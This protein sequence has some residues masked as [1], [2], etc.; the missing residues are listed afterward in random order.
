MPAPGPPPLGRGVVVA[1]RDPAPAPWS[2]V[3]EVVVDE[4]A[5]AAPGPV[6]GALHAAWAARRPVVVRLLVEPSAFRRPERVEV[7]PWRLPADLELWADRLH[8]LVWANT[9]D[10][11]HGE[12]VWW[13]GRKAA[14]LGAEDGGPA[15]VALPD[16]RPA[17]VDGGPRQPLAVDDV[18]VHRE[19]VELGR[20]TPVRGAAPA[21]ELAPDQLAAVTSASGAARIVAPAGSGKTRVLAERLRHLVHDRGIEPELITA[22]AYNRRAADELAGRTSDVGVRVRTIHSLGLSILQRA[23]RRTVLGERDVRQILDGMVRLQHRPNTDPMAPYLEALGE[24]RLG[25]RDPAVVE[26]ERDDVAGLAELVPRYRARL[27]ELGAVDFDEQVHGALEL[28]LTDPEARE[29]ARR[30]CRHLLVDEFQDL[31]PA[32]VLLV[33]LLAAPGYQLFGV[34]DDDQVIYGY[35]G[36]D[37]GFL[38][39]FAR[40]VPAAETHALEVNYR[41]PP[42][43]VDGAR[44]LLSY[45]SRR[46]EKALRARPGRPDE[47]GALAVG[48]HP[49][50]RLAAEVA[51]LVQG[52]LD[53]G[54]DAAEVAVLT[55]VNSSLLPAQVALTEAGVP[56]RSTLSAEV[57]SR[58]GVRA[59]LA[60]LRL[61]ADPSAMAAADLVE[62]LRRP[63]RG[64]SRAVADRLRRRS[65]WSVHDVAT[66]RGVGD[67]DADKLD[68][69][70]AD[71][72]TM[73][74]VVAS[75]STRDAL[76]AIRDDIGLGGAMGLLDGTRGAAEGSSHLDDLEALE[77]VAELHPDPV[78][79]EPWLRGVLAAGG[80]AAGGCHLSTVHRVKGMEWRRVVVF[81]ATAGLV[82][83]RLATD[84]EEE[85]R[86]FHV[87]ITRGMERV[88]VLADAGRPS[89]FL[90][91][92]TGT[93]PHRPPEPV[94]RRGA[95]TPA[96]PTAGRK[97]A[98][99]A[100]PADTPEVEA[101]L[102][103]LKEWRRRRS[104]ADGV[105]AF[106][107]FSDDHLRGIA[108]RDPSTLAE[109]RGCPG[110]GPTK[111]ER[112]GDDVLLALEEAP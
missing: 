99:A 40:Y 76:R 44:Q 16:G 5:L 78:G 82:P 9:Y 30:S 37:P 80:D 47:P 73:G 109:L 46:V 13:W 50:D 105:P 106:I 34:G 61:G 108:R 68:G 102:A 18:V 2:G 42:A 21:S 6:V 79:F 104:R 57:L 112:Y 31:T 101:R 103:A 111:L 71:L 52:W 83:H 88:V 89:P 55:R 77:Q 4:A 72:A 67:R 93:A 69:F 97:A 36:A 87:A 43:V 58:T 110:V 25:L 54:V 53:E 86:V 20:L 24:V 29:A 60:W 74:K 27:D 22:V 51:R 62:V 33:R 70:A 100:E 92:L 39:D 63:S 94:R 17:W 12:P 23:R 41:C 26:A 59:A 96:A 85:R 49:G 56:V 7:V 14:R 84:V 66:L 75:G 65:R 91:E 32:F 45:N 10:A 90:D 95:P 38:V 28:L 19:S 81:G 48:R 107:V 98:G 1:G 15:D 3:P 35:A 11:R 64:F 8:F